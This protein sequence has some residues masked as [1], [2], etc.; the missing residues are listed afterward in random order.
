MN[1]VKV[2]F[3]NENIAPSVKEV[4]DYKK[5][6]LSIP[7]HKEVSFKINQRKYRGFRDSQTYNLGYPNF[8][9]LDSQKI[10]SD[11]RT[12]TSRTP[13]EKM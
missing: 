3:S 1:E 10:I 5:A 11:T 2:Y 7:D 6:I 13:K 12:K 8:P 4:F 9:C